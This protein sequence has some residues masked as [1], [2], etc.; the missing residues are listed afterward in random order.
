MVGDTVSVLDALDVEKTNFMG[1]SYGGRIGLGIAV[2]TPERFKSLI[3][4]GYGAIET[5]S[6]EE[7]E[8]VK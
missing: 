8:R 2:Y 6:E 5:D 1:F 3:I 4:G 7:K